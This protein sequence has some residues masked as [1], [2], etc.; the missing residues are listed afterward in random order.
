MA[1]GAP[2]GLPNGE[3]QS[4][5]MGATDAARSGERAAGQDCPPGN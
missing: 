1:Y 3:A 5:R 4:Q 2:T